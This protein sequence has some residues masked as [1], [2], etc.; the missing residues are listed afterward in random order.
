MQL[1]AS[2]SGTPMR[3]VV[4]PTSNAAIAAGPSVPPF[5]TAAPSATLELEALTA[6]QALN[7]VCTLVLLNAAPLSTE[8]ITASSTSQQ[9][10]PTEL[11]VT[12]IS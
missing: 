3:L 6:L 12:E 7:T 9:C 4:S 1:V 2:I 11:Q 8:S 10:A 5:A